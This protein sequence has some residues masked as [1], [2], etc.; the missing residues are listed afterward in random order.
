MHCLTRRNSLPLAPNATLSNPNRPLNRAVGDSGGGLGFALWMR[1][2]GLLF[3]RPPHCATWSPLLLLP[4]FGLL[5]RNGLLLDFGFVSIFANDRHLN[6]PVAGAP[7][8]RVIGVDRA[9][10]RIAGGADFSRIELVVL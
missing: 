7:F 2:G 9:E 4:L 10:L 6:P 8:C 5:H 3:R 1:E